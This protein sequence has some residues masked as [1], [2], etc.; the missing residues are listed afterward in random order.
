M[1]KNCIGKM[2]KDKGKSLEQVGRAVGVD[3]SH[4]S[5]I[6]SGTRSAGAELMFKL[7]EYFDCGVEDLFC[8]IDE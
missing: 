4:I 5:K 8:R 6:E 1:I 7:A 3:K 2:R